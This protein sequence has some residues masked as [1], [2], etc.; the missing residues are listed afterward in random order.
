MAMS[1]SALT[2]CMRQDSGLE[3]W[4]VECLGLG[5]ISARQECTSCPSLTGVWSAIQQQSSSML[6]SRAATSCAEKRTIQRCW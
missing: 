1:L 3:R 2:S 4:Q 5:W 6:G